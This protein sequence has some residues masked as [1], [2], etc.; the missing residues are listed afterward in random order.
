[1]VMNKKNIIK[2]LVIYVCFFTLNNAYAES[3]VVAE[4]FC[5]DVSST[6]KL[7][8]M[9]IVV[10]K[11]VVPLLVIIMATMDFYKIVMSGKDSDFKKEA[12][13]LGKRILMGVIV[14]MLPSIIDLAVNSFD[15]NPNADYKICVDCL[16]NPGACIVTK[17]TIPNNNEIT[18]K[19]NN[20]GG[21][22]YDDGTHSGGS[23]KF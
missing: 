23:G 4:N 3:F 7:V 21:V 15:K 8:G 2:L 14:F 5:A 11:I 17:P 10:V 19:P 1:M 12:I 22:D 6:L 20:Q 13:I 9:F 16:T 18:T